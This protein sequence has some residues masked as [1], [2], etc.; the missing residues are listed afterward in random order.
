MSQ[1]IWLPE[2]LLDLAAHFEFL[3]LKNPDV[4]SSYSCI[5][6]ASAYIQI[7]AILAIWDFA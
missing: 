7:F 5:N 1:L 6:F 3:K 2:A 4:R